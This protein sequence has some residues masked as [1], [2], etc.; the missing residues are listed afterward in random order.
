[1]GS[2]DELRKLFPR[3]KREP[4]ANCPRCGGTGI[5]KNVPA[6]VTLKGPFPCICIFVEHDLCDMAAEG[7]AE[8]A[9]RAKAGLARG[10]K[11]LK[12]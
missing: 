12:G 1:M 5:R 6:T 8:A 10:K 2:L 4:M 3:A 9:K 7:L 11:L